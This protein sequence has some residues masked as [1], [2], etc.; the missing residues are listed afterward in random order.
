[1]NLSTS[2]PLGRRID[3]ILLDQSAMA[4]AHRL[5]GFVGGCT[6]AL[7]TIATGHMRLSLSWIAQRGFPSRAAL[8]VFV[9][10]FPLLISYFENRNR[11]DDNVPRTIAF[12]MAVTLVALAVDGGVVY[13][14]VGGEASWKIGAL[15]AMQS[16]LY[17]AL[18]TLMLPKNPEEGSLFT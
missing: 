12:I 11:V 6:L 14:E 4:W 1:M 13:L 17:V 2:V 5:L 10:A 3:H 18:G 7:T 9:G 15:Y 16:V 8:L